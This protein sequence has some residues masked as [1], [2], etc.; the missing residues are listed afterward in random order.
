MIQET[1]A[2]SGSV[3]ITDIFPSQDTVLGGNAGNP[4]GGQVPSGNNYDPTDPTT[5]ELRPHDYGELTPSDDNDSLPSNP[6]SHFSELAYTILPSKNPEL[7]PATKKFI[8]NKKQHNADQAFGGDDGVPNEP[9]V[10]A[11]DA[12][13]GGPTYTSIGNILSKNADKS[14]AIDYEEISTDEETAINQVYNVELQDGRIVPV[15]QM[16]INENDGSIPRGTSAIIVWSPERNEYQM[17]VPI[18][19]GEDIELA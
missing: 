1:F 8:E 5:L 14:I 9:Q 12:V 13:G 15:R 16:Q 17:Q 18:E 11:N 6:V 7:L 10:N 19:L 4:I 2:W 3:E